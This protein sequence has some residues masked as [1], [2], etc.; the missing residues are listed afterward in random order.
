MYI[1]T[2]TLT[3]GSA[4][5]TLKYESR[6]SNTILGTADTAKTIDI[7]ATITQTFTAA[8]TLAN[9][10][11]VILRAVHNNAYIVVTLDPN[12]SELIE[13]LTTLKIVSGTQVL[14][15]CD[16]SAFHAQALAGIISPA[17]LGSI[18]G[19][20]DAADSST[21]TD[22]GAGAVS[23]WADKSG[24]GHTLTEATNRP[25]TGTRTLNGLNVLDFDGTN[26][27][28]RKTTNSLFS[29][30]AGYVVY[31]PDSATGVHV[32]VRGQ[33]GPLAVYTSGA[34][35]LDE[36]A[37]ASVSVVG[38]VVV[39][40]PI[41]HTG[42]MTGVAL[43]GRAAGSDTGLVTS[44]LPTFHTEINVGVNTGGGSFFDGKLAE[45]ILCG[46]PVDNLQ[47]LAIRNYLANKWGVTA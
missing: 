34:D 29:S 44:S 43:F 45:I 39:A 24:L 30:V 32:V 27:Q 4:S 8:A 11:W 22:A 31:E 37:G 19:W 14:V 9:G 40:T 2:T 33:S 35:A 28:L 16:G 3:Q 15:T 26:D 6:S 7:T 25:T 5:N 21:I 42:R 38:A 41:L 1:P 13:G 47:D 17:D 20:W 23:A 10:W 46:I 12:G 36:V 18:S